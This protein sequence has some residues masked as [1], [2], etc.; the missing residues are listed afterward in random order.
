MELLCGSKFQYYRGPVC[1][2]LNPQIF[3]KEDYHVSLKIR[4]KFNSN[5]VSPNSCE[6]KI[7]KLK[8]ESPSAE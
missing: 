3:K 8:L 6:G 5:P 2:I 7:T 4:W 1:K